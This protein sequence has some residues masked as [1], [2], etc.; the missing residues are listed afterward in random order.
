M[1]FHRTQDTLTQGRVDRRANRPGFLGGFVFFRKRGEH[2]ALTDAQ[3]RNS[4]KV[5]FPLGLGL[6]YIL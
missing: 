6:K 1:R 3:L 4:F 2:Y 5:S